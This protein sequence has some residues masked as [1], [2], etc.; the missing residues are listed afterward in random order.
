VELEKKPVTWDTI[1]KGL[2]SV[3]KLKL[4]RVMLEKP[5][6][7]FTKYGLEKA[8]GLKPINVRTNLRIL[9]EIK[10]VKEYV[11]K[12]RTYKINLENRIVEHLSEFLR[13]IKYL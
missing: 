10:W 6:K 7:A 1:E 13:K 2:G 12:P 9:V 5:E 4:L 11:Y 3:G 8:T